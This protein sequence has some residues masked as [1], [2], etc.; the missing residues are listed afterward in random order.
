MLSKR[1]IL[2]ALA[3]APL[4][5]LL[6]GSMATAATVTT[7]TTDYPP[8]GTVTIFG[9][10]FQA[11]ESVSVQVAHA[12]GNPL[13]GSGHDPWS[14]S[15]SG[16]GSFTTYWDVPYDDNLGEV[17]L[18][19]ATG[20]TSGLVATTT[21]SDAIGT[22]LDQ[23][24][25]GTTSA[26]PE[27][28]NG[29]INTSN[30]CY[31]EANSV[32]FRFFITGTTGGTSH[33]Y[34]I[35][36]EWTKGGIHAYDY[37]TDYDLS[38]AGPIASAGGPCG[39]ISTAPPGDCA[40]PSGSFAF[41]DFTNVANYTGAIPGDF[42]PG[43]F[44]QD[45]PRNIIFYNATVDSIGKYFFGGTAS[46]RTLN[47][48]V[49]FNTTSTGSVG[50]FWGGHLASG[51]A[52]AWTAG[53]GSAS[54]AGAP[55]HMSAGH[56]DGAGGGAEDRSIQNGSICLAPDAT[57]SCASGSL[58]CT[59][60]TSSCSAASG[61]DS[62]TWTVVGGTINS[63]QGTNTVNY[64]ATSSD[65]VI[66]TLTACN[67]ASGCSNDFC[68]ASDTAVVY[69]Q[70][71]NPPTIAFGNDTSVFQ[72]T[73]TQICL[74]YTVS[75]PDGFAG[76]V[77]TKVS[78]PGTIDTL[79]NQVCYT[80][81]GAGTS[82]IIVRVVD[83]CG[84]EDRD[85]INVTVTLNSPPTIALGNDTTI[86]QCTPTQICLPYLV[87]DP[88]GMAG[89]VETKVS[90]PGTIDT[91]NNQVCY[92]PAG[93]GTSTIIVRVVDPCGAED[94]DTINVTVTLNS[95]PSIALGND[96][97]IFQCTPT[98]ICL[99][100]TV[101]DPNGFAGLIETKV[102]GPGTIDTLNNQVCYTPASSGTSTI[103]VRVVDPC[104]AEDRDT[105][106]VT[107]NLNDP[108]TIAFGADQNLF[109]CTP[110]QICLPYSVSDPDGM[111]GLIET[112][113]SGS[114]TIDTLNNQVCF[115]PGASGT[116]TFVA[117][118][119]D[120][121]GA[122]DRDTINVTVTLNSAP[123]ASCPGN[124]SFTLCDPEEICVGPF[125]CTDA[126]ANLESE[127][128]SFGTLS[129]GNVCFTPD[130]AG[131]Y[132]IRLICTDSCN[133][134]DTCVTLV[135]VDYIDPPVVNDSSLTVVLCAPATVCFDLP[136]NVGGAPPYTWTL[137]GS[138]VSDSICFTLNDDTVIVANLEV[139]DSC[140]HSDVAVWTITATVNTKP[141]LSISPLPAAFICDA[142]DQVCIKLSVID[143]DNGLSGTSKLGTVNMADS[144]VCFNPT[145][146]GTYCDT[147]VISDSCGLKDTATYCIDVE[148]NSPPPAL[149]PPDTTITLCAPIQICVG[150]F[151]CNDPDGNEQSSSISFGTKVGDNV[152][153]TPDT[154]GVYTI[155]LICTDSCGAAD[156]CETHVTVN[157]NRPPTI[158]FDGPDQNVSQC[159]PT[160]ICLPYSVSDP[161][162][163]AG[164]VETLVSG[165]GTIDTLNNQVCFTPAASGTYTFV[166]RVV[167]PCGAEDRDTINVTVTLNGPPTIAFGNDT[168]YFLCAP[169]QICLPY[170]VS[171]P[172]GPAGLV[173]ALVSG[174]GII[175]TLNNRV[176]FTPGTG[177]Y[178]FVVKVT[179][180]CGAEDRD[181]INVDVTINSAP[182][183]TL[184][185]DQNLTLCTT[186]E[187]C[188]GYTVS[189]PDGPA[190]LI[191][192]LVSGP[193]TIDTLNNEVCFTPVGSGV[194]TIVVRVENSCGTSD[195]D[196]SVVTVELN[197]PPTSTCPPDRMAFLCDSGQICVGPFDCDDPDGNLASETVSF[198]TLVGGFVCFTP[199]TV[200]TYLIRHICTDD[201]GAADTCETTVSVSEPELTIDT[202]SALS[203]STVEICLRV[204]GMSFPWGGF[205][206][207]VNFDATMLTFQ[208]ATPGDFIVDC[209][210]EYFTYRLESTNP[211]L[212]RLVAIADMNNSN[213][214][215]SCLTPDSG[216]IIACLKF[217]TSN[218]RNVACQST[219]IRFWWND[220]GD[221]AI[222]DPTGEILYI[223]GD[224]AFTIVDYAGNDLTGLVN[225]GG[226]GVCPSDKY[227]PLP[228]VKFQGGKV[229]ILCP[230]EIDDRGDINLNALAYEI[231]DAVLYSNYF[232]WGSGVLSPAYFEAQIAASDVNADGI[233]LTVADLVYLIRVITGDV[234]AVPDD[235]NGKA[236]AVAGSIDVKVETATG[237][238]VVNTTSE[239]DLGASLFV[240]HYDGGKVIDVSAAGR[241]SEMKVDY[242]AQDGELRVLVYDIG[243]ERVAAGEGAILNITASGAKVELVSVEAATFD[244]EALKANLGQITPSEFALHQNYPNP[245]NPS[246]SFT[247][248]FPVKSGYTLTVYNI[249]GQVV[250][251]FAGNAPA[252]T[253]RITWDGRSESGAQ[254]ASGVYFYKLQAGEF[255]AVRK[256]VLMK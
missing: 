184:E 37:L 242:R 76:L 197:S 216:D 78:G 105:I 100:Y 148:I 189:D 204:S 40:T 175:D 81:A 158:A 88:D 39:T 188:V 130:T 198:G 86:S 29:N 32:P 68:C 241:A 35:E 56:V 4:V 20:Q 240:F 16:S 11:N 125:S 72:C 218:D 226:P 28:A 65:S 253:L 224:E 164:L 192:T 62:Y 254:V 61:A 199:D 236:A 239:F 142:G 46:D 203:N 227:T 64:T 251:S 67:T 90:G 221:N 26:S 152:C 108:P 118:V 96:T 234:A 95:P 183:V 182:T 14:V 120:P 48:K 210:W 51:A 111:A 150:P 247:V 13:D 245:F 126:N 8:G 53:M 10:G 238:Y 214:H 80:P 119:T 133:A 7:D 193:G 123:V 220:C 213:K 173:E 79:N 186:Q 33:V 15:A 129:G 58:A 211:G 237:G 52:N 180:P 112:L 178:T 232:I 38:E 87:S 104:G 136:T 97:S 5:L 249:A 154:S 3:S 116:Y 71:N 190:N 74:P 30:S 165:P 228:C 42:F 9:T 115:T 50:F 168:S 201:C 57:I 43:G 243:R 128:V 162:G 23:L 117:R 171:D 27:W 206:F 209:D 217:T 106:N 54:V 176:C 223:V 1:L 93:A 146:P 84:A 235:F 63:G 205:D 222:S 66:I 163:M 174:P 107:V 122:E 195:Q 255:N 157:L 19:T 187:I 143:P 248:D 135:T 73:P 77:E 233:P 41:P 59:N 172:D 156:T 83:P 69:I 55:Y 160:Q 147:V 177:S 6:L 229:R 149:C 124:A 36:M 137:N 215:P 113:V 246:T 230:G 250:R 212:I 89:L 44:V 208:G 109:Q 144:T 200:G 94:R 85:T 207:L 151:T 31:S 60:L 47:I 202:L 256:M 110:T 114:G 139:T 155:R 18:V 92:T 225:V 140:G 196:T 99:P 102:S 101:S 166:I 98:Q 82:T 138:P 25:N 181:T 2:K 170:T 21:F 17:M 91:L 70:A 45:G 145:A 153:F 179:D 161:D 169:T 12:D 34:T 24:Q 231:A 103:I 194:Y 191:E 75:D 132:T 22:N 131:T 127:T 121:C 49:Y 185:P 252:G 219:Q 244:G 159:A 134:A 141:I 167:D